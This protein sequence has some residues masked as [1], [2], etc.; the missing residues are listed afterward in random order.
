[1]LAV[2][3]TGACPAVKM[4]LRL[5]LVDAARLPPTDK[6]AALVDCASEP[7]PFFEHWFLVP[8]IKYLPSDA[9]VWLAQ[10][11][12]GERLCGLMPLTTREKYGRMPARNVGNWAHYQCFMGTPLV[13]QGYETAFWRALIVALDEADWAPGFLSIT[14]MEPEGPLDRSLIATAKSLGRSSPIVHRQQRAALRSTLSAE[15]YLETHARAK[16]RKEWR[17]LQN[18]LGEMGNI[19][20]ASLESAEGLS[21]WCETFLAL[22]ASGWKGERGAALD[23]VAATRDFFGEMMAGAFAAGALAFHRLDVDGRAIAML[24]NFRTPPGSWSFKIAHDADFSRFSPGVMIELKNLERVLGDPT[25]DWMDSCAVENHPMIDSLWAERRT[26]VQVSVPLKG[27]KRTL[28]Y[29][30]CRTAETASAAI[31]TAMGKKA[32]L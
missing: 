5:A 30:A 20:F 11:W 19:H 27:F 23:N 22:E 12:D 28:T 4:G 15:A 13:A 2:P 7:N 25:L 29:H 3:N 24:I 26:I 17:R 18:R 14:G 32:R 16:K 1:M 9:P 10:F 8:A 21:A 31:K 6:W